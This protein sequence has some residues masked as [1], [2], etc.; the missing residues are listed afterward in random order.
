MLL[1]KS[2]LILSFISLVKSKGY[3]ISERI[4]TSSRAIGSLIDVMKS[5]YYIEFELIVLGNDKN[6]DEIANKIVNYSSVPMN[7]KFDRSFKSETNAIMKEYILEQNQSAIILCENENINFI[8]KHFMHFDYAYKSLFFL[9][10]CPYVTI[11]E[12]FFSSEVLMDYDRLFNIVHTKDGNMTLIGNEMLSKVSCKKV[13]KSL[14][15]FHT[16][17]LEWN[18][19]DFI[20][21]Y[22]NFHKCN[23]QICR[24]PMYLDDIFIKTQEGDNGGFSALLLPLLQKKFN[25]GELTFF[26]DMR[27]RNKSNPYEVFKS[28]ELLFYFTKLNM[29][30]K[31]NETVNY[32]DLEV[33]SYIETYPVYYAKFDFI[34]TK[35]LSYSSMEK[36]FLPFDFETWI[37]IALTF[38][39]GFITI[40][41]VYRCNRTVQRFVFGTNIRSPS[42]YLASIFFGISVSRLPGRNFARF[43]FK[44]FT[45]YC[46]IIRTAYQG[47]MFEFLNI[48][49]KKPT[50]STLDEV[51]DLQIPVFEINYDLGENGIPKFK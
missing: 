27:I 45:L 36:L 34:V 17:K 4:K 18:S 23:F 29:I 1:I 33:S 43:L 6:L 2:L 30:Y 46:L 48:D 31:Y 5:K 28:C 51:V 40:F 19:T 11:E 39:I 12:N 26:T 3:K 49:L 35:G 20:P 38:G 44:V 13:T 22:K 15:K 21:N 50:A 41:I 47:K 42:F 10:F 16:S 14:N 9:A 7:I 24:F 37:M 32:V 25:I 8:F